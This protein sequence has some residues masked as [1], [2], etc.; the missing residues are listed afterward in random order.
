[1]SYLVL[2]RKYRPQN[3][4]E[5][6]AQE[7]ITTILSNAISMDRIAHAYLFSGPRGVGKTSLARILAKSLNCEVGMT[8]NPCNECANCIQINQGTSYDVTEIDGA[9]NTGVDDVR[10]LQKELMFANSNSRYKIYIID[11]VHMLSKNAFNALLKTLE[12]PPANVVFIFATTE[13]FK[14]LP[15]ILSRCQRYDFKRIPN[16][17]I[18]SALSQICKKEKFT[19]EKQALAHIAKKADGSLRDALSNLDQV[20]S[21]SGKDIKTD[22]VQF[23]FG[24]LDISTYIDFL[25]LIQKDDLMALLNLYRKIVEDGIEIGTMINGFLDFL[26]DVLVLKTGIEPELTSKTTLESMRSLAKDIP[27]ESLLYM[28]DIVIKTKREIKYSDNQTILVEMMFIKLFRVSEI[29]SIDRILLYLKKRLATPSRQKERVVEDIPVETSSEITPIEVKKVEFSKT[30]FPKKVDELLLII[31][32]NDSA[33]AQMVRD[34]LFL[35]KEKNRLEIIVNSNI[36]FAKI[37]E[38]IGILENALKQVFTN[39]VVIDL[40][41]EKEKKQMSKRIKLAD[42]KKENAK[43]SNLISKLD[44]KVYQQNS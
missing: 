21:F 22:D 15:T 24:F 33:I 41:R 14:V 10:E 11:E 17:S 29:K 35:P 7:H 34:S 40:V 37:S 25:D 1:M 6:Y 20:V 16:K 36:S 19:I 8:P 26:M 28:I 44:A 2:A 38:K 4:Q 30:N 18:I 27:Q 3:F 32:S 12:E 5:V 31:E 42:I 43:L 9:S 13:P 23:I 39:D